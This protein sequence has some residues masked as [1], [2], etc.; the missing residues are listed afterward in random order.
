M[1]N[2]TTP[3]PPEAPRSLQPM[4]PPANTLLKDAIRFYR[5]H[6]GLII[7]ITLVPVI[8]SLVLVLLGDTR[9]PV[10]F[11]LGALI[12]VIV[13]ALS[14]IA[15]TILVGKDGVIEGDIVGAYKAAAKLFIP[16]IWMS[17]LSL[18]V[19]AS[20]M[21]FVILS[22]I[23]S[24]LADKSNGVSIFISTIYTEHLIVFFVILLSIFPAIYIGVSVSLAIYALVT[25]NKRGR[26]AIIQ[27]WYY[28]QGYWWLVFG[29]FLF[30]L[31]LMLVV[32]IVVGLVSTIIT[33]LLP[34]TEQTDTM[35][36]NLISQIV[37]GLVFAP[38]GT[39]YLY[40]IY[41]SLR[42]VKPEPASPE[43]Y[44]DLKKKITTLAIIGAVVVV[45]FIGFVI[46]ANGG[47]NPM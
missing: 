23:Y 10:L 45:S 12:L 43:L 24:E 1:E 2:Q 32:S 37:Q 6:A 16:N 44:A 14:Y 36:Y 30:F 34:V 5:K 9:A 40:S 15:V 47:V 33:A 8:L 11:G 39:I 3:T 42:A 28:I 21:I 19:M 20:S 18:C 41:R 22:I 25:E 26:D 7:G 46:Y 31:L 13:N 27:S 38:L 4:L 29:K 35:I 17:F